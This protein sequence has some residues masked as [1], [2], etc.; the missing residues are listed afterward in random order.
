MIAVTRRY[1]FPASHRLHS[2]EL[3]AFENARLYGKC[4]NPFGHGHDYTL[5]VT[6]SGNIDPATGL[7]VPLGQL[8]RLVEQKVLQRFAYRNIN[9]D[10]S[11]FADLVPTTEN[12]AQVIAA[13]L[14][15]NWGAYLSHTHA[16]LSRLHIQETE[17]NGFEIF[18]PTSAEA[19]TDL[20]PER[21][22]IHA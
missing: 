21:V 18:L 19:I 6:V 13:I 3:S 11:E 12:I 8:D 22:T 20:H 14:Q 15:Q 7:V 1:R 2:P 10:V 16:R 9:L 4:N 17:R 5:E